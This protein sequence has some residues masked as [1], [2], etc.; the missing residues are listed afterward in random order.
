MYYKQ[1]DKRSRTA[2]I[3]FLKGHFRYHTMNSGNQSTSYANCIKLHQ[4]DKPSDIDEETWW[5]MLEVPDCVNGRVKTSHQCA[6]Q[7]RPL[8][9]FLIY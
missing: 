1:V 4:V 7:N 8:T 3:A 2:L 9:P 5:Q 6:G